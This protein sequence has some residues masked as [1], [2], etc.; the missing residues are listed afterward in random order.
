MG[1]GYRHND[2]AKDSNARARFEVKL[3]KPGWYEVRFAYPPHSNRASNVKIEIQDAGGTKSVS[4]NQRN[5]PTVERIF[6]SLGEFEFSGDSSVT[7]LTSG[8]DGYVVIDAVQ[9]LAK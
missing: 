7:I 8:T 1:H 3:P 6:V 9:W 5:P 4:V 2:N